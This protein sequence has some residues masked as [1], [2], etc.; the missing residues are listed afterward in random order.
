ME[1]IARENA[2]LVLGTETSGLDAEDF[3]EKKSDEEQKELDFTEGLSRILSGINACLAKAVCSSTMAHYLVSNNGSRFQY[4]H[5]FANLLVS[6]A[7][8]VMCGKSGQ[9]RLVTS[10]DKTRKENFLGRLNVG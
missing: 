6:Q 10:W 9:F 2:V 7:I 8:D 5:R 3:E 1:A 4:S